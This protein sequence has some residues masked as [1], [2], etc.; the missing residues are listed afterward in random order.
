[1]LFPTFVYSGRFLFGKLY[2]RYLPLQTSS[3]EESTLTM[4]PLTGI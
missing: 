2:R 1:L 4:D 3:L